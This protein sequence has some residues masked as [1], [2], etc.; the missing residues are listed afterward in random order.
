MP[1][2]RAQQN[3]ENGMMEAAG[4]QAVSASFANPDGV[5]VPRLHPRYF[6]RRTKDENDASLP[7]EHPVFSAPGFCWI[8]DG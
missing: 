6:L 4:P 5:R 1:A 3:N 7:V 8:T 2:R